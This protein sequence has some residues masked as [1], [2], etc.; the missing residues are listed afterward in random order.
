[1]TMR[2]M[3]VRDRGDGKRGS[4]DNHEAGA[5]DDDG[6]FDGRAD[7]AQGKLAVTHLSLREV[8]VRDASLVEA[9][10]E[11]GR[12]H[13]VRIHLA[14]AGF[15]VLGDPLYAGPGV[16]RSSPRL[17]LH[18]FF[19][20]FVHPITGETHTFDVPLA[21]DLER[22]RRDLAEPRGAPQRSSRSQ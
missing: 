2:S 21:D 20:S 3:L 12:T 13:Q 6:D 16:R 17:A 18:A 14:E 11:T 9:R 7:A 22:L 10:L 1:M 8:L 4:R 19:L 15:P 5:D